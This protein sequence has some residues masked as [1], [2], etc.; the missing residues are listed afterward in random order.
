MRVSEIDPRTEGT[1]FRCLHDERP[2][3]PRVAGIRRSWYGRFRPKG[4]RGKVLI[5]DNEDVVGLCQYLPIEHSPFEGEDLMAILCMWIHGYQH[6]PGNLQG[7]GYGRRL[8]EYVEEDARASGMKGVAVWGKD[9]PQWN[10]IS[11]YEH[12]GYSR[13][14][15]ES[16]NV[17][18]W[19]AFDGTA[20]APTIKRRP[21][22]KAGHDGKVAVTSYL[23]GWCC[24]EIRESLDAQEAV[25][26]IEDIAEYSQ[27]DISS[28]PA[29]TGM[30][31]LDRMA[32]RPDGPPA[33]VAELRNDIVKLHEAKHKHS[34]GKT[35]TGDA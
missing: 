15:K 1:F 10:P 17:L 33:S 12:M 8:L 34:R 19:K 20:V 4:L 31:Y 14:D 29:I 30:L 13:V 6:H 3:D 21:P 28:S 32:Y 2:D 24:S 27:V 23:C 22:P 5:A 25:E 26:G 18:A 11:F 9:F 35:D 7:K 16:L